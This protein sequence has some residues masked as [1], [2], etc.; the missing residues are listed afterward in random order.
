M[1]GSNV[2]SFE[3]SLKEKWA[4]LGPTSGC[5]CLRPVPPMA[6]RTGAPPQKM[7]FLKN[8]TQ[9]KKLV[10]RSRRRKISFRF[11]TKTLRKAENFSLP[12]RRVTGFI[13]G[14]S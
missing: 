7:F 8:E 1:N 12:S 5:V 11:E 4:A 13:H 10:A 2:E 6:M 3:G 14:V 9:E